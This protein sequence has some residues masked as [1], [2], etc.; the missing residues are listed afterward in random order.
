[1]DFVYSR[2]DSSIWELDFVD[3]WNVTIKGQRKELEN[4]IHAQWVSLLPW[5]KDEQMRKF[6][7]YMNYCLGNTIDNRPTDVILAE[8][9]SKILQMRNKEDGN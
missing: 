1:M 8:I 3:F 2:Y 5:F 9:D 7:T 4:R 6:D